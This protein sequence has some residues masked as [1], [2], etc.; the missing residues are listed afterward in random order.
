MYQSVLANSTAFMRRSPAK[1]RAGRRYDMRAAA[2][3]GCPPVLVQPGLEHQHAPQGVLPVASAVQ[4]FLPLPP[5]RRR[6]E[7]TFLEQA[8]LIEQGF[9]PIAQRA[10]Q[11]AV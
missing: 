3:C 5:D 4:V 7:I 11:P 8:A 9:R 1:R 2:S 6:V 10:A